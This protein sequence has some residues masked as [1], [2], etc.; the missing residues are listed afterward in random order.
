VPPRVLYAL[1]TLCA[2]TLAAVVGVALAA[3]DG[4]RARAGDAAGVYPGGWAGSLRPPGVPVTDFSLRDQ[5]GAPVSP[6]DYRG[7]PVVLAFLYSTCEDTCPGTAQ[8]IRG[9]LDDL[10]RD[11]PVLAVSVDPANDTPTRARRFVLEQKLT[12]RMRFLVGAR[13]SLVPVWRAYGVQPQGARNWR[14]YG[15]EPREDGTEHAG[16][17]ILLDGRGRQRIGFPSDRLTSEG[18]AHDLAKLGA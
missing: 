1:A 6:A 5:D 7:R 14:A 11:V 17:V 12:G 4:G 10:G 2:C 13:D 15:L 3:R 9:A 18:L 16:Y 8:A